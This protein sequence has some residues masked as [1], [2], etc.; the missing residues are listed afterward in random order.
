MKYKVLCEVTFP[1]YE[2]VLDIT[3]PNNKSVLYV[4]KMLDNIIKE[5]IYQDYQPKEN[6]IL[7]NKK[8]GKIYDKNVLVQETDI[9]NGTKLAYY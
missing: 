2:Q 4:C 3:I 8:T 9:K 1:T 5:S 6:S 7:I